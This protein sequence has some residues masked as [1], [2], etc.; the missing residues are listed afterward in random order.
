MSVFKANEKS[1]NIIH[2]EFMPNLLSHT[3]ILFRCLSRVRP[4]H[5]RLHFLYRSPAPLYRDIISTMICFLLLQ[6]L[7]ISGTL[8]LHADWQAFREG[9]AATQCKCINVRAGAYAIPLSRTLIIVKPESLY[10]DA[11]I[12]AEFLSTGFQVKE[13]SMLTLN[14]TASQLFLSGKVCIAPGDM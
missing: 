7:V 14:A 11:L 4:Q 5:R 8:F 1:F 12:M 3:C 10:Q 13:Q 2:R 6:L 9:C